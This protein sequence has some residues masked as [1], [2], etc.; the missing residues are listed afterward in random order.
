MS[1][2]H[3]ICISNW[4]SANTVCRWATSLL[5]N[6]SDDDE[7]IVIDGNS[8]DGSAE[9]LQDLCTANGFKFAS[10]K[11]H[12]GRQRQR[13]FEMSEGQYIIAQVDTDDTLVS[14]R[15]AKR[16]YHEVV[17]WDPVTGKQRAF[18]CWG[19]FIIPRWMLEAIGGYPDLRYYE[20]QLV[21]YRLA[22]KGQLTQSWKISTI[23]RG[24]DP[25]KRRLTFRLRYSFRR[26]RE[27]LRLRMFDE[28]SVKGV[29]LLP[30]AWLASIP[31]THYQF[32]KDWWNLDVLRDED[33]LPWVA[34][35]HLSNRLL[36]LELEKPPSA[37]AA[38]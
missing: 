19:F 30:P 29:L 16:L 33:I 12:V 17:E 26:I 35:E 25:K 38:P 5:A 9:I 20:D 4:N 22:N 24:F 1:K 10:M 15:E 32:Q 31:R 2:T 27:G 23:A 14:L 6:L 13:A 36:L 18:R 28:W 21:A 37:E 7:V 11:A 8:K 3:S 34:R